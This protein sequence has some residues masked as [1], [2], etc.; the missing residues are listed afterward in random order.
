[1]EVRDFPNARDTSSLPDKLLP[2]DQGRHK[3]SYA[4]TACSNSRQ[5]Q[6]FCRQTLLPHVPGGT[7]TILQGM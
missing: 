1:M 6:Y 5:A 2:V 4:A 3:H 7:T